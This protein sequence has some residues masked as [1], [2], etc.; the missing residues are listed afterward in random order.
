MFTV[1][2]SNIKTHD[3]RRPQESHYYERHAGVGEWI[4]HAYYANKGL[5]LCK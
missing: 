4:V 1:Y 5:E 2:S 3:K